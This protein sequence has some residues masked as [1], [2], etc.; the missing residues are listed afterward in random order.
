[1]FTAH[2]L[3]GEERLSPVQ[4]AKTPRVTVQDVHALA[5]LSRCTV[6]RAL[7]N[8]PNVPVR[9][10]TEAGDAAATPGAAQGAFAA[11]LLIERLHS[12]GLPN[13]PTSQV[14]ETRLM[15]RKRLRS[16]R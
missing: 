4:Q 6:F 15:A 1:M 10:R 5:G 14:R 12:S 3:Q 2:L 16:R 11:T 9:A 7:R 8:L 13:P